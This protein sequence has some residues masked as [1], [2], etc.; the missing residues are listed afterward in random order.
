HLRGRG[1][2]GLPPPERHRLGGR[3]A[4]VQRGDRADHR[5]GG[6]A[7]RRAD[8]R[9]GA[10]APGRQER[11]SPAGRRAAEG[12]RD[13]RGRRSPSY[14]GRRPG[15]RDRLAAV[16]PPAR[17]PFVPVSYKDYY[18]ILGVPKT[19]DAK[20]IKSAYRKLARKYHPDQNPGNKGA[21]DRFKEI[22]EANEVLSDPEKRQRYDTLGPDW[23]RYA[24]A[25][26]GGGG[27]PGAGP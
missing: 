24:E 9:A 18:Q 13:A 27:G 14:P 25:G 5:R 2:P 20:A 19:A 10:R 6:P 17:I 12:A 21:A 22:N 7:R 3:R 26:A 1:R 23:E 4:R 11:D 8:V 16:R 15:P